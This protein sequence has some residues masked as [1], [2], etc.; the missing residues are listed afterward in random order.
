MTPARATLLMLDRRITLDEEGRHTMRLLL[1]ILAGCW[2]IV[3]R[4]QGEC[5]FDAVMQQACMDRAYASQL[6]AAEAAAARGGDQ[7]RG[8]GGPHRIPVVVHILHRGEA[9][10]TTNNPADSVI[11]NAL[12]CANQRFAGSIGS[13]VD[14]ELSFCLAQVD[15]DGA[16]TNGIDRIDGTL[17]PGYATTGMSSTYLPQCT[18][19]TQ[20]TISSDHGWPVEQ[21]YN[22]YLVFSICGANNAGFAYLPSFQLPSWDGAYMITSTFTCTGYIATHELGHGMGLYHTFEG[23]G[24]S[25]FCPPN[26]D[27]TQQGDRVCDTA[28]HR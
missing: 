15:P 5:A 19:P 20:Y 7:V 26:D 8:K 6:Q 18:G 23:D 14:T 28:P 17:Y 27:C 11:M 13:G 1:V 3:V 16:P 24:G 25:Q 2:E 4:A 21:Y 9:I 12:E 22:I 10:G